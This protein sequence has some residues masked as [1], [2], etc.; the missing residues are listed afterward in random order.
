MKYLLLFLALGVLARADD[1]SVLA[2]HSQLSAT[3]PQPGDTVELIVA[4]ELPAHAVV[5][6]SDFKSD[7]GPQP[8]VL[9]LTGSEGIELVGPLRS[10]E[11]KRKRD[12]T[13]DIELGYFETR[14][15]LRQTVRIMRADFVL[16]GKVAGQL[17]DEKEGTCTLFEQAIAVGSR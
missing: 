17:C 14:A 16:R 10:I 4:A 12:K 7:I 9:D 5:Y 13:W 6:S 11:A 2:W 1:R 8:T 3:S 15:E